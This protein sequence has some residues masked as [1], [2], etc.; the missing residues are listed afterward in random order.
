MTSGMP[1]E[2]V[3]WKPFR[4]PLRNTLLRNGAIALAG[5]A[6][7]AISRGTIASWPMASL[8]MLW[9][10]LGGHLVEL[11]FLNWLRPRIPPARVTQVPARFAVWWVGGSILFLAMQAT[12][13]T[14]YRRE[15]PWAWWWAGGIAFI[16][17]EL[18]VH[19]IM[20]MRGLAN[21][22]DGRG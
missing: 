20:W 1:D 11:F 6:V 7:L 15:L 2:P 8:L 12:A 5:G 16:G 4:E 10:T 14:F 19:L 3:A 21:F 18:V 13:M 22:Y 17:I 9:P